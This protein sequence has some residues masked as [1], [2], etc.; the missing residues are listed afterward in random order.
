MFFR[1]GDDVYHTYSSYA[2]G[3]ENLTDSYSLLKVTPYGRQE[4]WEDSP[5]GRPPKPTYG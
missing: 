1:L 5:T 2:R 4:D 3:V